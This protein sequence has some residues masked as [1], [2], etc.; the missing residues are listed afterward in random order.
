MDKIK[1][2]KREVFQY[3]AYGIVMLTLVSKLILSFVRVTEKMPASI[4]YA[5]EPVGLTIG[6]IFLGISFLFP[7]QK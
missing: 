1:L 5:Y 6:L 7:K 2:N 4:Y 3:I